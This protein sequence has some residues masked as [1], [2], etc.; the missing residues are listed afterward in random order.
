MPLIVYCPFY[1]REKKGAIFCEFG[2]LTPPDKEARD[3]IML[4]YCASMRNYKK[5]PFCIALENYYER[6]YNAEEG[7][8]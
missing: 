5:C 6:K 4:K 1:R 3:E 8:T 2:R 7:N